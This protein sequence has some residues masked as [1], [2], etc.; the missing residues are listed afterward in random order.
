MNKKL[1]LIFT[2]LWTLFIFGWLFLNILT[3]NVWGTVIAI[4]CSFINL[5]TLSTA[6]KLQ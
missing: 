6:I 2:C 1:F 4:V 5:D 3:G